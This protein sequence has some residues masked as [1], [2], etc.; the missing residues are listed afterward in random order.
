MNIPKRAVESAPVHEHPEAR[1]AEPGHPL[2][3]GVHGPPPPL[4]LGAILERHLG[5][6]RRRRRG[7]GGGGR[8]VHSSILAGALAQQPASSSRNPSLGSKRKP[9]RRGPATMGDCFMAT[10]T[11]RQSPGRRAGKQP[12]AAAVNLL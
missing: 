6:R 5:R 11:L 12:A 10:S 1:V 4:H 9:A 3:A 2:V 8:L 7:G